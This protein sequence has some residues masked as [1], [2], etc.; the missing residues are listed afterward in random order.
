MFCSAPVNAECFWSVASEGLREIF[1]SDSDIAKKC[2]F[3][4][5]Q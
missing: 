5:F 4:S 3:H 2:N 1:D